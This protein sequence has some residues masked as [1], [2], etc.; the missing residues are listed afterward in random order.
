MLWFVES[1]VYC[2]G[3]LTAKPPVWRG[4]PT[5]TE[6][7]YFLWHL[8]WSQ[9]F[10]TL[11]S[12]CYAIVWLFTFG[13]YCAVKPLW[14][15]WPVNPPFFFATPWPFASK[16]HHL[17]RLLPR[18]YFFVYIEPM[19]SFSFKKKINVGFE[20]MSTCLYLNSKFICNL[21]HFC[22]SAAQMARMCQI[23]GFLHHL[24]RHFW[25]R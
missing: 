21:T 17:L 9:L 15:P 23:L 8:W 12:V 22:L 16:R 10:L 7:L 25:T 14:D 3:M 2:R 18:A 6:F 1:A 4:S 19:W 11:Q 20:L 5:Y 24:E 13:Y